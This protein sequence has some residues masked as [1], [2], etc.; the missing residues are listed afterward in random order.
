MLRLMTCRGAHAFDHVQAI[1]LDALLHLPTA[2]EFTRVTR[3]TGELGI[4]EEISVER[5]DHIGRI[6]LVLR[7]N[8]LAESSLQPCAR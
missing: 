2:D 8:I 6:H 1:H 5:E 3:E 4:G 7:L